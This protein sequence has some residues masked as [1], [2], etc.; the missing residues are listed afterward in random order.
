MISPDGFD[1]FARKNGEGGPGVDFIFGIKGGKSALQAVR[2]AV[3]KFTP[4]QAKAWLAE[5][6]MK[7]M[8]FEAA[9]EGAAMALHEFAAGAVDGVEL[10]RT[11]SFIDVSGKEVRFTESDLDQIATAGNAAEL[12]GEAPSMILG[13]EKTTATPSVGLGGKFRRVADRLLGAIG[14]IPSHIAEAMNDKSFRS[15]SLGLRGGPGSW[16]IDHIGLLGAHRPA[17]K[18]L[19]PIP[20]VQFAAATAG[21]ESQLYLFAEGVPAMKRTEAI[22]I[23]KAAKM[24]E[25]LFAEAVPDAQVIALAEHTKAQADAAAKA[26][27]EKKTTAAGAGDPQDTDAAEVLKLLAAG[28][29]EQRAALLAQRRERLDVTLAAAVK[30]GKV[31]PAE[32]PGIKALAEA[33]VAQIDKTV[34]LADGKDK[35]TAFDSILKG[36]EAR[37]VLSLLAELSPEAQKTAVDGKK[38]EV[39]LAAKKEYAAELAENIG[40]F[41]GQT[42]EQYVEKCLIL[43]GF[44][45]EEKK[46]A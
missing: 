45:P 31:T 6:Q 26:A 35:M 13:H 38:T 34:L 4:E 22:E 24:P 8:S 23:L 42:E 16:A 10:L 37:P 30:A 39:A 12:A 27:A 17:V 7:P 21:G 46:T 25:V 33:C 32:V 9:A 43:A 29:D 1:T 3:S 19:A 44:Y 11:G 2:F 36:I 41:K 18:G 14:M 40:A 28:R 20:Q 15:I 5:H